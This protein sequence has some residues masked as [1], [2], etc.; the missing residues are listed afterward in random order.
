MVKLYFLISIILI[1]SLSRAVVKPEEMKKL[2]D[3]VWY[4][5]LH[6]PHTMPK[7]EKLEE[8]WNRG[9][10]R[11]KIR[12]ILSKDRLNNT[13]LKKLINH[14]K[15]ENEV[16]GSKVREAIDV[17]NKYMADNVKKSLGPILNKDELK[18]IISDSALD[19]DLMVR[20]EQERHRNVIKKIERYLKS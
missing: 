10:S 1:S 7:K 20:K 6:V 11:K 4:E 17:I 5:L 14:I 15:E 12:A 2:R 19:A 13:D 8:I 9:E 18:D 3:H 16:V